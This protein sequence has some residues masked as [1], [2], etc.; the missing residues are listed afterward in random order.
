MSNYTYFIDESGNSGDIASS[1]IDKIVNNQPIFTLAC[2]GVQDVTD[3]DRFA[4]SLI[5]KY[6]IQSQELKSIRVLKKQDKI[7][8]DIINY[9]KENNGK[10][11]I[12]C[13]DKKY[14]ICTQL[15]NYY[16]LGLYGNFK[17]NKI[18]SEDPFLLRAIYSLFYSM[19]ENEAYDLFSKSFSSDKDDIDD[20]NAC[21]LY[22]MN[23][24]DS[25]D[26][27]LNLPL[28]FPHQL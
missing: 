6:R 21:F 9:L 28:N 13:V 26:S 23:L 16:V 24:T 4:K 7:P 25:I 15:V 8:S 12:E 2:V 1:G 27:V 5:K 10:V 11:L 20:L 18:S 19:I 14:Q 3:L 22:F 17:I